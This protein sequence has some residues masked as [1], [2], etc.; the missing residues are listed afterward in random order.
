MRK[1]FL[2]VLCVIF[3]LS[4]IN[5]WGSLDC[6]G[7]DDVISFSPTTELRDILSSYDMTISFW[8][9]LGVYENAGS[10]FSWEG[11]DD[12]VFYPYDNQGG[13]GIRIFW[14]DLGGE[15]MN[16]NG[17]TLSGWNHFAF[18]SRATNDHEAYVNGVSVITSSATGTA[19]PW[20]DFNLC[21]RIE[22]TSQEYNGQVDQPVIWNTALSDA[23]ILSIASSRLKRIAYQI[24]PA[25]RILDLALDECSD[26][27]SGDGVTF[28]DVSSSG[29]DGAGDDGANNTGLTCK[30]QEVQTY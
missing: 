16:Q 29:N 7:T 2:S 30:A 18:V 13:D 14:R 20:T 15:I 8:A 1:Y 22:D 9:E 6:D 21:N 11:T 5:S 28:K 24:Q 12:F 25:N 19:G 26:G 10:L 23:Q 4:P 27:A 3:L 17:V